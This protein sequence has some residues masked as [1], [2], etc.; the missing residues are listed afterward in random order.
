VRE[1]DQPCTDEPASVPRL[2]S[3]EAPWLLAIVYASFCLLAELALIRCRHGRTPD[4]H[5]RPTIGG[6]GLGGDAV[7]SLANRW[8]ALRARSGSGSPLCGQA[9]NWIGHT[10][11]ANQA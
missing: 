6:E 2:L 1:S 4:R 3:A 7:R 5:R 11:T 10:S 8:Q 9:T